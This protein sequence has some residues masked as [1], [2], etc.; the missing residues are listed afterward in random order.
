MTALEFNFDGLVGPT[1][2]YGGLGRGNLASQAHGGSEARP[3]EAALQGLAK[4]RFVLRLG[5]RQGILLPH[6]RPHV[7]TLRRFGFEGSD[8]QVI[9]KAATAAP[10]LLSAVSS[11]S[12]MWT[13]N[14]ATVTAA[15]DSLDGRTHFTPANLVSHLHRSIE[16]PFATRQLRAAFADPA[17]FVV[18][19]PLPATTEFGDEG[20]ANH[21]RLTGGSHGDPGVGLFVHGPVSAGRFPARHSAHASNALAGSH[22]V[23]IAVHGTQSRRAVDAGVFHNDVIA[24]GDRDLLLLHEDAYEDQDRVLAR[25]DEALG[26]ALTAMV[27]RRDDLSLE[28]AVTTYLFNSQLLGLPDGRRLLLAPEDIRSHPA[29]WAVAQALPHVDAV[30]TMD[31]R[32]SMRNGGGPACL[33]LRVVLAEQA[34]AGVHAGFLVDESRVAA[35][36][37]WVRNHYRETLVPSDL[38]DPSLLE[39]SR[40]ALD[41]LTSLLGVGSLYDF[42]R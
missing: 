15:P 23:R 13:A 25:L 28:D 39:E 35:L 32:Q 41:A 7:A 4:M 17:H 9:A 3:R 11:A 6:E 1:H 12:A 21:T 37:A 19:D 30:E 8:H 10:G 16:A 34:V 24:V 26:G 29:A 18:H 27:V 38:A 31:L 14:A 2:H 33:R 22:G 20:A 36:E 42:Q 5:L 40:R